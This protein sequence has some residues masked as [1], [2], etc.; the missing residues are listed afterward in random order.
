MFPL[1]LPSYLWLPPV[2]IGSIGYHIFKM[3]VVCFPL[4]L[5]SNLRLPPVTI[6]SICYHVFTMVVRKYVFPSC[7]A[8][9]FSYNQLPLVP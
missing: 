4:L 7:Y 2:T 6:G 1:L 9:T 3:V 5:P 8:V